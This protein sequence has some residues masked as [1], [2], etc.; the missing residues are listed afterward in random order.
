MGYPGYWTNEMTNAALEHLEDN[1]GITGLYMRDRNAA[2]EDGVK[3]LTQSFPGRKLTNAQL[4]N[5][6][7]KLWIRQRR[8][9]VSKSCSIFLE[10]RNALVSDYD[11]DT[12]LKPNS[13]NRAKDLKSRRRSIN[14]AR[15]RQSRASSIACNK[16]ARVPGNRER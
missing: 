10:G 15:H 9:E 1:K 5:K 3:F 14:A 4:Y 12:L 8:P 2:L 13:N 7:E 16:P 11:R 6:F